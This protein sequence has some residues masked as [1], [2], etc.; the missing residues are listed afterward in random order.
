MYI[1]VIEMTIYEIQ[2]PQLP[3]E[4]YIQYRNLREFF[5]SD[6]KYLLECEQL[7]LE[8][9]QETYFSNVDVKITRNYIK[10]GRSS[11]LGSFYT[12][13][14]YYFKL[15]KEIKLIKFIYTVIVIGHNENVSEK[16]LRRAI[17][18]AG[19]MEEFK[20]HDTALSVV[21]IKELEKQ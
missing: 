2:E 9:R 7:Y 5:R 8:K 3:P 6:M 15:G 12:A 16:L 11:K 21:C 10:V 20:C 14:E 1:L 13:Q 19:K 4:L 17:H 18:D